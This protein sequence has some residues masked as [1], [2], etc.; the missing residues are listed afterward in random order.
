MPTY[1]YECTKCG[2]TFT[3]QQTVREHEQKKA[4]CPSCGSKKIEQLISPVYV[5]TSRKS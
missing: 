1:E 3:A 2:K 5:K 4:K